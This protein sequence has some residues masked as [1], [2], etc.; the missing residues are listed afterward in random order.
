MFIDHLFL[1]SIVAFG[2]GLSLL[3]YRLFAR[4][5]NWPVGALHTEAPLVPVA[6]GLFSLVTGLSFAVAR[7]AP[8]GGLIIV[9]CGLLLAVFWTGFLRVGSQVSLFLAPAA[10]LFLIF[11]WLAIPIGF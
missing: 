10:A 11:G 4:R 9:V 3:V 2:L 6:I 8:A 7:G 5:Y 1:L